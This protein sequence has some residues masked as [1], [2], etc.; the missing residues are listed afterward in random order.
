M[1]TKQ[2]KEETKDSGDTVVRENTIWR[3]Y[4]CAAVIFPILLMLSHWCI[5]YVFSQNTQELM[6]Y[7]EQNEICIV[8]IYV[9]LFLVLPLITL[10]ASFL[11]GWCNFLR[12]PFV[13]FI[14]INVERWY[15]GSWFCTNEMVDTHYIL[16]YC[17]LCMYAM[18]TVEICVKHRKNIGKILKS[19]L[20]Y[21]LK[22]LR[23]PFEGNEKT[24]E[25][26]NEVMME[27]ERRKQ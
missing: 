1:R 12:I 25:L 19:M 7:S 6:K 10:P 8:W 5:F 4:Q 2:K 22:I 24:N 16:I 23:K 26:Y 11:Y 17:I 15:Y 20:I 14:F 18:D 27:M 9:F 3:F 21:L 13:Y